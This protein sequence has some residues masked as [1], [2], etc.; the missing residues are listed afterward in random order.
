M[1]V[2][3]NPFGMQNAE[4]FT[5]CYTLQAGPEEAASCEMREEN[6]ITYYKHK[7][8][9]WFMLYLSILSCRS[10]SVLNSALKL[11]YDFKRNINEQEVSI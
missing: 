9:L 2:Q 11:T 10:F 4:C 7:E 1:D 8:P 6:L 3:R 5:Y